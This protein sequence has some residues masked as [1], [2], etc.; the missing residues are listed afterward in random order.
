MDKLESL[1][2]DKSLR[3]LIAW[4]L[5]DW[6]IASFSV[7]VQTFVFA[8]YFTKSVAVNEIKGS[9]EWGLTLGLSGLVIAFGGP[10]LGAIADHKG[11]K[12]VWIGFFYLLCLISTALLWFIKPNPNY[13]VPA[14]FL[15]AL[16]TIGSEFSFIF[17]N[18]LLPTLAPKKSIGTWS[19]IGWGAGY[20]GGMICLVLTLFLF[21]DPIFSFISIDPSDAKPLRASFLLTAGWIGLFAIPLFLYTPDVIKKD[22]SLK[23]ALFLGLTQLKNS[24]KDIYKYRYLVRFLIARMF[25]TDGLTTLFLFGGVYAAGTFNMDAES[26]LIFGIVLN[27]AAGLG[28]VAFAYLDDKVGSKNVIVTS[29]ICLII[30][31]SFLLNIQ[32]QNLFWIFGSLLGLFVGPLQSS[33]RAYMAKVTPAEKM[34]QMFGLFALS[35]KATGFL[36]PLFVSFATYFTQS[37][38]LGISILVPFLLIGLILV[39]NIPSEK[40]VT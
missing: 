20:V 22:H 32:S 13:V 24:I 4:V 28:A 23:T 38:R 25:Y 16:G 27:V 26:I 18:A 40:E 7:V 37:Q 12:K 6:A 11:H 5:Y 39:W 35:G 19:G 9:S 17:Y 1:P 15:V 33:S 21:I 34:N 30:L 3:A 31:A 29:L 8:S 10:L 14:L 36:G 2:V